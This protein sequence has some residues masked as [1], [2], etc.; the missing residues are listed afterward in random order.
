[1]T[2]RNFYHRAMIRYIIW[3]EIT[4]HW[5]R[6]KA[7]WARLV[8]TLYDLHRTRTVLD[9]TVYQRKPVLKALGLAIRQASE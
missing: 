4:A 6:R 2:L 9:G 8:A 5:L 7:D 1:M 3:R